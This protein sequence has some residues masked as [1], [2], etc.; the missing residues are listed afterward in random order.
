VSFLAKVAQQ[1]ELEVARLREGPLPDPH[2]A[3]PVRSLLAALSTPG[4]AVIAEVKRGSPSEGALRADA[5]AAAI[6]RSYEAAG[7]RAISVLTD[8]PHFGG[9][10]AD[11]AQVR[12]AVSVPVLRKDF[13]IDPIQVLE[14]RTAGADAVLLIVAMLSDA[15]LQS[16]LAATRQTG[17]EALIEVHTQ[18]ELTRAVAADARILGVNSRDLSDLSIDLTRTETLLGQVPPGLVR[19]AESGIKTP[20][21]RD[22]V[23]AAGADAMLVGS[24]LMSAPDPGAALEA[25]LCG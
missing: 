17:M 3:P 5:D 6:A 25:L 11:L 19:V 9:S 2:R 15:Q 24:A 8:G 13:L 23:A 22:R 10:L 14:A 20:A 7:A 18:E 12:G 16:L 1:K 21:D 4:L